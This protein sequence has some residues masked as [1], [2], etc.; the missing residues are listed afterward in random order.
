MDNSR[1]VIKEMGYRMSMRRKYLG[2]TQETVAEL[3]DVSPQ[4]ISNA[5]NGERAISADKLYRISK[6]LQT[7]SDYLL[8]GELN[9]FDKSFENH[10]LSSKLK[11]A[12]PEQI[13]TINQIAD[14]ILQ[15]K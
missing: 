8:C 1:Q 7:S 6:A 3:A 15:M 4:L 14:I 5:E 9:D 13:Q 12:T 10:A 11:N 2:L